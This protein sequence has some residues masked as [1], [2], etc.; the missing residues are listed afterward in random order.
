MSKKGKHQKRAD[1]P[2]IVRKPFHESHRFWVLALILA[3]LIFFWTPLTSSNTSIQWD[4]ADYYW[5]VQKYFSDELHAGR[6]PFW[7]PY[8]WSGY[9]FL[10]D[11]QVGAWYPLNWPFFAMGVSPRTIQVENF[12]HSLLACLG[13]YFLVFRLLMN[14]RAAFLAG[15][16][17]GLCGWFVGHSSHTTMVEAAAWLPWLLLNF[18]AAQES[19]RLV[20]VIWA[21]LIAG[22]IIMAGHFQTTLYSFLAL[23]L[24][25]L[26]LCVDKPSDSLRLLSMALL[27]PAGGTLLSAVH[28][29]PG[30]ELVR[31]SMRASLAAVTRTEGFVRP[32]SLL[33]LIYPNYYGAISGKYWGPQDMTQYYFYAG[34]ALVPL[35]LAGLTNKRIRWMGLMLF[36]VCTWYA[37]GR[38][39]GLYYLMA[40][41]PGFSSIRAPVNIWF[42]PTL[43][44][45][46]LAGAGFVFITGKWQMKWLPAALLLFTFCDLWY[47][48]STVNPLAYARHSY[49]EL[50]GLKEETFERLVGATVPP[51]TRFLAPEALSTFGPMSHPLDTR[52]EAAYGYG[53]LKLQRYGDFISAML[54]NPKLKND[55][56]IS[57]YYEVRGDRAV[58][59]SNPD[60]L[61]RANFPKQLIRAADP[62]SK[63]ILLSLDPAQ[64]A[65]VPREVPDVRQDAAASVEILDHAPGWYRLRY[66]AASESVLRVS[67]ACYPGWQARLD[68]SNLEVFCVD[69]ALMGI[70][71]PAGNKELSFTYH[72]TYFAMGFAITLASLAAC[73]AGVVWARKRNAVQHEPA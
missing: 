47:W 73:I 20:H 62:Q 71:V 6:M 37:A 24:F 31:Q 50:Y 34:L 16:C 7:T 30:V 41:L 8:V 29:L 42:V 57:R 35:A 18:L 72:P 63:R 58:I 45:A 15:L 22:L 23:G 3:N 10:A 33:T 36:I 40:R 27:I 2:A 17:Y 5:V 12:L 44:L 53:P 21:I 70:M 28:T 9:P 54:E 4:A 65:I 67:V 13:A 43:G 49:D 69:H 19:R 52:V 61:T 48:N 68:R 11:P 14:K 25:A 60:S 51:L 59:E 46:L 38:A 26:A 32:D 1:T 39:G 56:N 64:A 66:H 55:L